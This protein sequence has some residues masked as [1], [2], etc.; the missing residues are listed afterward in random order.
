MNYDCM[1]IGLGGMGSSA[2]YHLAKRGLRVCG[3]DQFGPA[4]A[5]GS[6]HGNFRI[7]RKAYFEHPDYV[8][9]LQAAEEL[10]RQLESETKASLYHRI[11]VLLSGPADGEAVSGTLSAAEQHGL[12]VEAIAPSEAARRWPL[13]RFPETHSVVLDADAG[14]LAVEHCVARHLQRA[15]DLG[16]ETCFCEPVRGWRLNSNSVTVTTDKATRTADTVVIAGGAW[17]RSLLGAKLPQLQ[18]LHKLQLWHTVDR[19]S[20]SGF[21]E[22]PAFYFETKTGAFYGMRTGPA[23]VKLARHTLGAKLTDPS[24]PGDAASL[25]ERDPCVEFA[26][27]FLPGIV[28]QPFRTSGCFYTKSPDG[29]FIVD[30]APE[31]SRIVYATGFSGHGFKFASVM[32]AALA[33]LATMGR[34]NLPIDFLSARRFQ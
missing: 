20:L 25:E 16:A 34:T 14:I 15:A 3:L 1:V 28:A 19:S 7:F 33:D 24:N 12:T 6:S 26:R 27:D 17:S 9:L 13:L 30:H 4:H 21:S 22:L 29:H 31:S 8:P 32:G 2:L 11:G 10:W 5:Q 23:E 18:V